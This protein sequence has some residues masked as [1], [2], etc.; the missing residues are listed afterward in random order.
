MPWVKL[1][2]SLHG[3]PKAERAGNE[4]LGVHLL[5][6]S[7]C[8][9]YLTNGKI[10]PEFVKGKAGPRHKQVVERLVS[11]GLWEPNGNGWVIHDYLDY[12]PSREDVERD[13]SELSAKRAAA[14][15][16]GAEVANARRKAG[17]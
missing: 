17:K 3:H 6:L 12:N 2:D 1:D 15:R 4:A 10:T 5:A 11:A 8:G 9:A 7:Y 16:R 13:R 14:G